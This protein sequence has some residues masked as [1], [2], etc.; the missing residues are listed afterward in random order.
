MIK[1]LCALT[2]GSSKQ[3]N[4]CVRRYSSVFRD[5][6]TNSEGENRELQLGTVET[7]PNIRVANVAKWYVTK[8]IS[9]LMP[10]VMTGV[11]R[12]P[13]RKF[14]KF[15]MGKC[16]SANLP[17][18]VSFCLPSMVPW[19]SLDSFASIFVQSFIFCTFVSCQ[20]LFCFGL[21]NVYT[22]VSFQTIFSWIIFFDSSPKQED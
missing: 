19:L 21:Y 7:A 22:F 4:K 15:S 1:R 9:R 13:L 3:T 6:E 20:T 14:C 16:M 2:T 8:A 11:C 12:Y 5:D 18:S 10:L 17:S